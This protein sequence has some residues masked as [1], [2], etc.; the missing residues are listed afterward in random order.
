MYNS[1]ENRPKAEWTLV[2][3]S[4][5]DLFRLYQSKGGAVKIT[6]L[7][8][9]GEEQLV[10]MTPARQFEQLAMST[11]FIAECASH[12]KAQHS[13]FKAERDKE[14][15]Q[16]QAQ[17]AASK[18]LATLGSL[19]LTPEQAKA[20]LNQAAAN[21]QATVDLAVGHLGLTPEQARAALIQAAG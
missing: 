10:I 12:V 15:V 4:A 3:T 6:R 8:V 18:L 1:N 19:G 13:R 2:K 20:A 16:L 14:K 17:V 21:Q 9:D 11:E 5:N 7:D